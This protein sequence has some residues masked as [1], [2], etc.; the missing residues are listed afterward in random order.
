[1]SSFLQS[2]EKLLW[3]A[4]ENG[5]VNLVKNYLEAGVNVNYKNSNEVTSRKTKSS[6]DNTISVVSFYSIL[7]DIHSIHKCWIMIYFSIV[8]EREF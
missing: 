5:D 1:M 3:D 2:E 8:F 4:A 7:Y 6:L